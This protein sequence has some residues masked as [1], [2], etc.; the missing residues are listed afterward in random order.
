MMYVSGPDQLMGVT[1]D[2][3]GLLFTGKKKALAKELNTQDDNG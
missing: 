2:Q 3:L 1:D